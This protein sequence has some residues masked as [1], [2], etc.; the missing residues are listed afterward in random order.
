METSTPNRVDTILVPMRDVYETLHCTMLQFHPSAIIDYAEYIRC[1]VKYIFNEH[2]NRPPT[3]AS[4]ECR[5]MLMRVGLSEE[6]ILFI[7]HRVLLS[8]IAVLGEPDAFIRQLSLNELIIGFFWDINNAYD[9]AITI[10][11]R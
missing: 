3:L 7:E 10:T 2:L 4:T 8:A 5:T 9:M 6:Q 1:V 11:Y